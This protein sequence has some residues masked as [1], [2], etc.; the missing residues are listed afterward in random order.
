MQYRTMPKTGDRISVLG[1]GCMRFP[2]RDGKPDEDAAAA[3][4]QRA[5][6]QGVNYFDTA[7]PYHGGLSEGIL[8]RALRGGLRKKVFIADK[9][10]HWECTQ[11]ED[12]ER[13]LQTQ[14]ERLGVDCIDYYLVH[15]LRRSA[16]DKLKKLGVKQFLLK[17]REQGRIRR[18]GFSFHSSLDDFKYIIDDFFWEF[19]QIQLNILDQHFQAGLAGLEYARQ[20]DIGVIVMEPL[21]GG[22]LAGNVPEPVAEV[23][24]RA[25]VQRSAAG[26]A[27][28]WVWSRP[29]V[30]S[31][32]S[33]M[34][35]VEQLEEN[36]RLADDL[37]P[38]GM[39][40]DELAVIE[41]AAAA[42]RSLMA[43]PCTGCQYCRDCPQGI[44]IPAVFA[45]YN[46]TLL[47]QN[48]LI[49]PILHMIQTSERQRQKVLEVDRCVECG[50]CVRSCP[51]QIK[52][53]EMLRKYRSWAND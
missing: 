53:P 24:R 27:L 29:G 37:S 14:L 38:E 16:W 32:L 12:L 28:Q 43:V 1:F 22:T 46:A 8:G 4:L 10:P 6:Q 18:I 3:Q 33:G 40:G 41:Q 11:P 5:V 45:F 9:L 19:C 42:F 26:W 52:V 30:V 48:G 36:C 25:P 39:S 50:L 13:V 44:D 2:T 7:W 15:A 34:N 23:Y 31:L 51:Q 17:A 47:Q 49:N 20:R 35:T 21:R